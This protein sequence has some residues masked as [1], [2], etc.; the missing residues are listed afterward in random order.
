MRSQLTEEERKKIDDR[1]RR[2]F[3]PGLQRYR[4]KQ[5]QRQ[6]WLCSFIKF[7]QAQKQRK[8]LARWIGKDDF[9]RETQ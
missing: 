2:Q 7:Y 6:N 3:H 4:E 1:Y 8:M 9:L 5:Q